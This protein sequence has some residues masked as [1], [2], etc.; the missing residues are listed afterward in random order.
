MLGEVNLWGPFSE[1]NLELLAALLLAA[2]G[3][4]VSIL[5]VI[6]AE[7]ISIHLGDLGRLDALKIEGTL[8]LPRGLFKT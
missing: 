8:E 6:W 4:S 2:G 3:L 1:K 7:Q 5:Q